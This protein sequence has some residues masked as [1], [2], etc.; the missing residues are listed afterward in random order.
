MPATAAEVPSSSAVR[1]GVGKTSVVRALT[2]D[3][4][5]LAVRIGARDSVVAGELLGPFLDALPEMAALPELSDATAPGRPGSA[6]PAGEPSSS[7][8]NRRCSWVKARELARRG[9]SLDLLRFVGLRMADIPLLLV[10]TFR[11]DEV[12][13]GP[14]AHR[15]DRGSGHAA[16]R[17][18]D[19]AGPLSMRGV[20]QLL[21][22]AESG[23]S[24]ATVH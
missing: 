5:G 20:A 3:A 9:A 15:R 4:G 7:P 21:D 19:P 16:E 12:D 11:A 17:R 24:A 13:E 6:V 14:P 1:P 8:P 18:A 10:A 23:L 22:E 2:A